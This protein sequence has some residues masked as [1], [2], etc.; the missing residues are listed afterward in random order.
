[1]GRFHLA[2]PPKFL[3]TLKKFAKKHPNLRDETLRTLRMLE[4]NPFAPEL[5]LH[6]LHGN[7]EG[8]HAVSIT[9][10]YRITLILRIE[11]SEIY[12]VGIGTH[13]EV[14]D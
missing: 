4:E 3:R 13:D 12:L 5:R 6:P 11:E 9:Y 10:A 7:L 14:Y 1:M 2:R 8:L